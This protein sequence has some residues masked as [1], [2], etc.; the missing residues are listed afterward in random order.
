MPSTAPYAPPSAHPSTHPAA[1][2][3]PPPVPPE[4]YSEVQ[5]YYA[6]QI[7]ALDAGRWEEFVASFTE[8]GTFQHRRDRPPA[9]TRAGILAEVV[10]FHQRF[11]DDPVHRRHWF[12]HLVLDLRPDG[13]IEATAYALV[14]TTRPGGLPQIQPAS[15]VLDELV[16]EDGRLLTRSR[17]ILHD[18]EF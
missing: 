9:R 16:R 2:A 18:H 1:P 13:R 15:V 3:F 8:D 11:R 17:R 10:R 6:R 4:L 12:N 5:Q 7:Q 14:I